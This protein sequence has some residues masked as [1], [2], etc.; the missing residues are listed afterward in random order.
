MENLTLLGIIY[1]IVGLILLAFV[2]VALPLILI[3]TIIMLLFGVILMLAGRRNTH[4][5]YVRYPMF[6]PC[7]ACGKF[8]DA[9]SNVCPTCEQPT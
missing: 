2:F 4:Y 6:M 1:L 7:P 5:G 9:S 8:I 3:V